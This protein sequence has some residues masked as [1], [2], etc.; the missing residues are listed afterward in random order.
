MENSLIFPKTIIEQLN[1]FSEYFKT[2]SEFSI[3]I[4][5]WQTDKELVD[6]SAAVYTAYDDT[7]IISEFLS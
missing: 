1:V 5:G 2:L 4:I 6:P 3:F 7:H